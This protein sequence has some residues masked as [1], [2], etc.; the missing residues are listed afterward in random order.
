MGLERRRKIWL[1]SISWHHHGIKE[2][3]SYS[4]LNRIVS[5]TKDN[6][7]K[8][9]FIDTKTSQREAEQMALGTIIE[10]QTTRVTQKQTLNINSKFKE[11]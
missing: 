10:Y 11:D 9:E 6:G 7:D 1:K 4:I 2:N 5:G 3:A 8:Y